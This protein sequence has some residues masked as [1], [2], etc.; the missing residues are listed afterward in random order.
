MKGQTLAEL[1][2]RSFDLVGVI[3]ADRYMSEAA[4]SQKAIPNP[5][6]PAMVVLGLAYPKREL[7]HSKT[8][9]VP[10]FYTFGNDYHLILH[11]RIDNVMK[12]LPYAYWAGVDNHQHDERLAARLAG[13]GFF[14]KNQLIINEIYGSYIFLAIAFVDV[15]LESEHI[16]GVNDGCGGCSVCIKACPANALSEQGYEQERCISHFNQSKQPLTDREIRLN[17]SLFGCDV[18]QVVCPKNKEKGKLTHPEFKSSGK[19]K[20]AVDDLFKLSNSAFND[21]YG[22]MA[23]AWRGK[24]ILMRNALTLL[25][26]QKNPQ[27]N[28]LIEQSIKTHQASWYVKTAKKILRKLRTYEKL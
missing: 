16:L 13:L 8:H 23:Y 6:Y 4:K 7:N 9:L 2:E 14:G 21:K 10:S 11:N 12:D 19:E 15:S 17:H 22:D 18:C 24:T 3:R 28:D 1:F 20:V 26:K 5:P 27:Y 25:L